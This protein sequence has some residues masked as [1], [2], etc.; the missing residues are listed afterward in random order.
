M[1]SGPPEV[2]LGRGR[3]PVNIARPLP[4]RLFRI[5]RRTEVRPAQAKSSSIE[6]ENRK[7]EFP[8]C[9]AYEWYIEEVSSREPGLGPLL[10]CARPSKFIAVSLDGLKRR[11]G[12]PMVTLD[13]DGHMDKFPVPGVERRFALIIVPAVDEFRAG[14]KTS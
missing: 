14:N 1:F 8:G 2:T 11:R 4:S 5:G 6:K 13:E 7:L 3:T 9:K 10:L 12:N